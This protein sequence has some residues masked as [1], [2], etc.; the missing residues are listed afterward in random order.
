MEVPRL[1]CFME[2]ES[3]AQM[4]REV[5]AVRNSIDHDRQQRDDCHDAYDRQLCRIVFAKRTRKIV[6]AT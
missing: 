2:G 3:E 6:G 4:I 5:G 1:N